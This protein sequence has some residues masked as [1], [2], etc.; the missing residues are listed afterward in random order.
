[1]ATDY[2]ETLGQEDIDFGTGIVSKLNPG[3]G[4]VATTQ[5]NLSSLAQNQGQTTASWTPGLIAAGAIAYTTVSVAGA[6]PGD[7]VQWSFDSMP[8][9][10]TYWLI[11]SAYVTSTGVVAVVLNNPVGP[12][13]TLGAGN[14]NFLVFKSR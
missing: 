8:D 6:S 14:L 1:M 10:A 12:D 11:G 13:V 2:Y 3:G 5:V 4:T 9:P 7:F